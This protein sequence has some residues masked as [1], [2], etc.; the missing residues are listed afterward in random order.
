[1]TRALSIFIVF[2]AIVNIGRSQ[3]GYCPKFLGSLDLKRLVVEDHRSDSIDIVHTQLK[4]DFS[5]LAEKQVT[6]RAQ[7]SIRAL[8]PGVKRV[9]FDFEGLTVDRVE[10]EGLLYSKAENATLTLQFA[11]AIPTKE[12]KIIAVTYHG[13]PL[14]DS[15]GWGGFYFEGEYA[16]NLGVGFAADPHSYG[17]VWFPCFD[18]FIERSTFEFHITTQPDKYAACNGMLKSIDHLEGG[19]L[20]YHWMMRDA[21]PSYLSC[22]AIGPYTVLSSTYAGLDSNLPVELFCAESDSGR[23]A[24]S[25]VHL[26][27]A[28][29]AFEQAYGDYRFEKV[30][31]SLVPFNAGAMEHASNITY[32][33]S[34]A[35]GGLGS[36]GLMV[37]EL[38][39][40]WWGNNITC[41]T[42]GDMWINEGWATFSEYLF[43]ER[44]Y[45]RDAYEKR[46]LSDLR[47]MLQFGHHSEEGY[48][49]VAGQPHSY[50]YG[51][52]V[53]KKG[54]LVAHN[55]RGYLGDSAFFATTTQLM[56]AF[57]FQPVN[58]DTLEQ[59][60]SANANMDLSCFFRDWVYN[61]GWNA[62]VLDSFKVQAAE[63]GYEVT[64][65]VQQKLK[66]TARFHSGVPVHYT[67]YD[68]DW[69]KIAGKEIMSGKWDVLKVQSPLKPAW[70]VLNEKNQQAG[71]MTADQLCVASQGSHSF[72][73]MQWDIEVTSVK[74]SALLRFE[75]IWC[76]PDPVK[77]FSKKDI[78]ISSDHYWRVGGLNLENVQMEGQFLYDGRMEKGAAYTDPSLFADSRGRLV[79]LHRS[80]S[81]TNW[82]EYKHY[83]SDDLGSPDGKMGLIML[84]EI[85][86]GEYVLARRASQA[87]GQ[88]QR[89]GLR[90]TAVYSE[91]LEGEI[92]L[93]DPQRVVD[94]FRLYSQRGI[95]IYESLVVSDS[96]VVDL[97]D[98]EEK[99]A[100]YELIGRYSEVLDAGN[101]RV[102]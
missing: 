58:S 84:K 12:E 64:L 98:S 7:L 28:I 16:W 56:S 4:L 52:H 78:Q 53:Y 33:I 37:H 2:L 34:A 62:I 29:A 5:K 17:R 9:N 76:A 14:Q 60:M 63:N 80:S 48:R 92:I 45:G 89:N 97:R 20:R 47:Y 57:Q 54:A 41:Q 40:M 91:P 74:D 68:S 23:T 10:A 99:F 75:Q 25:F 50:T 73:N 55:L 51:D 69:N 79:L 70:I 101:V 13:S 71:A 22:V 94:R 26:H 49:P 96:M 59:F 77:A 42:D 95:L 18:N 83:Q 15:S 39:H 31:Y 3:K 36:E 8:L 46:M 24:S 86:P 11:E 90:G 88:I 35:G 44:V 65:H 21:I 72:E 100:H 27:D 102:K 67:I 32:P 85:L 30:G 93:K 61:P 66:G 43:R 19:Y 81:R 1:M 38:A 87:G 82:E 6:G